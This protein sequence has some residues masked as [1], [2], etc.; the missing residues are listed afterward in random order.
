MQPSQ[1]RNYQ[2]VIKREIL[3]KSFHAK[4]LPPKGLGVT[5]GKQLIPLFGMENLKISDSEVEINNAKFR[6]LMAAALSCTTAREIYWTLVEAPCKDLHKYKAILKNSPWTLI[7]REAGTPVGIRVSAFQSSIYHE[8][9]LRD[10]ASNILAKH[11][12]PTTDFNAAKQRLWLQLERNTLRIGLAM[13]GTPIFQRGYKKT[14]GHQAPLPEHLAACLTDLAMDFGG[15]VS[16]KIN[17]ILAP[18]AGTG[19]LGFEAV[20]AFLKLGTYH[21]REAFA[22]QNWQCCPTK[23]LVHLKKTT[24]SP[25]APKLI[26]IENNAPLALSLD[27]NAK[28]FTGPFATDFN[29]EVRNQNLFEA[30]IDD[31]TGPLFIPMNPPLGKR[32][33]AEKQLFT[34]ISKWLSTSQ[35]DLLGYILSPGQGKTSEFLANLPKRFQTKQ[36][37]IFHGGEE[38]EVIFFKACKA[39][40]I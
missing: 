5:C 3:G 20:V 6:Q 10:I 17:A 32:L 2:R 24:R 19:T 12:I 37:N 34:N 26:F 13:G 14:T 18:F 4:V 1:S 30:K 7:F 40:P 8:G 27:Q 33:F 25:T 31:L 23:T 29:V 9:R 39:N 35:Q 16:Q 11:Q 38:L 21:W 22:F 28:L 15:E 36:R